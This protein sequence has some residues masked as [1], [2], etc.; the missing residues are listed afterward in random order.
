VRLRRSPAGHPN[1]SSA[2]AW[3]PHPTPGRRRRPRPWALVGLAWLALGLA[4]AWSNPPGASPDETAHLVKALG[5]AEGDLT[6]RR[7]AYPPGPEFGAPQLMWINSVARAFEVPRE[8]TFG[9]IATCNAFRPELPATCITDGIARRAGGGDSLEISHVGPYQPVP[10][11]VLG[12]PARLA[13]GG[14]AA[15]VLA[16]RTLVVL[17]TTVLVSL[18]AAALWSAAHRLWSLIGLFV[19]TTPMALFLGSSFS[20]SG[21]EIA[22]GLAMSAGVIAVARQA[23]PPAVAWWA[24]ISGGIGMALARTTGPFWAIALLAVLVVACGPVQLRERVR[25]GGIGVVVG[26]AA[27]GMAAALTIGWDLAAMPGPPGE[28]QLVDGTLRAFSGLPE[29]MR[30]AVGV[31]GWLDT[32][33]PTLAYTAWRLM[34]LALVLLALLVGTRR[35]RFV[36]L[37]S[38]VGTLAA[39]VGLAVFAVYPTNFGTQARYTLPLAVIVPLLAG[40]IVARR[41]HRVSSLGT[42][43]PGVVLGL[44]LAVHVV[45]FWSNARRNAVGVQ[46]PVMFLG[47]SRWVPPLGWAP[48][49]FLVAVVVGGA[50]AGLGSRSVRLAARGTA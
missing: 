42:R 17:I 37:L 28:P 30:Q 22:G 18:A 8:K 48:W 31:F 49:L 40:E 24:L 27:L 20:P 14:A 10:Y 41:R 21:I 26:L 5:V 15:A 36:L 43:L 45:A 25:Q 29:L 38:S 32:A 4:W 19:A 11:A 39:T 35:D 7:A 50:I 23:H 6:G 33:M 13:P 44:A 12:L 46:G 1:P 16:G 9:T 34:L 3:G 2:L 47:Q